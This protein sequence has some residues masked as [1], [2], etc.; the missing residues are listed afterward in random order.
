MLY[1][2]I[3]AKNEAPFIAETIRRLSKSLAD[4]TIPW[5][6][7]VADNGSTDGSV[8]AINELRN[9]NHEL[10]EKISVIKCPT[11][12]KGAAI[13][14]A[15]KQT[16]NNALLSKRDNFIE[17][18]PSASMKF[19]RFPT[20]ESTYDVRSTNNDAG[21]LGRAT[22]D[23]KSVFGFID[24]DLSADPDAI[25]GMVARLQDDKADI[26]IASRLLITKTTN[27]SW[28]RTLSSKLFNFITDLFLHLN[29]ADVQCGLKIMNRRGVEI[30]K[31]C[32]EDG[33]FLDIEFLAR[34]RQDNLRIVE[35]PVPWLEFRYPGR[36]SQIRH[37]QDGLEAIKAILR[38]RKRI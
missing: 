19:G 8:H 11:V 20:T 16:S 18:Q 4:L 13:R 7:I 27:R 10:R 25:A 21:R 36:K 12:G 35:I 26:V 14:F 2:V 28:L 6:I 29:V 38:I 24:A 3:P 31:S 34:A 23:D 9:T 37:F 22:C 33:W 1:L 5:Q 32:Q 30:L 15:S 17:L